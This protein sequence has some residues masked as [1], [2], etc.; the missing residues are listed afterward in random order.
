VKATAKGAI[1][2]LAERPRGAGW[3]SGEQAPALQRLTWRPEI[4]A[5]LAAIAS[6]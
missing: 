6:F 3:S 1:G 5:D 2:K 4:G